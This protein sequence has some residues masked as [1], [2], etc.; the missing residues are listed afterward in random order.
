[1]SFLVSYFLLL[2]YT[3][4][5]FIADLVLILHQ[6]VLFLLICL[7][8]VIKVFTTIFKGVGQASL[9]TSILICGELLLILV[10]VVALIIELQHIHGSDPINGRLLPNFCG[11]ISLG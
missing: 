4:L 9:V 3:L 5:V 11:K 7:S 2:F 6:L 10:L 1:M 8:I